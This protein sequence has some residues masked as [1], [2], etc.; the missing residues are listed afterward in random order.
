MSEPFCFRCLTFLSPEEFLPSPTPP[1]PCYEKRGRTKYIGTQLWIGFFSGITR[2]FL[3]WCLPKNQIRNLLWGYFIISQQAISGRERKTIWKRWRN[4]DSC[5][6]QCRW[7]NAS[8]SSAPCM[9][10]ST[11]VRMRYAVAQEKIKMVHGEWKFTVE[12]SAVASVQGVK[13][14]P[15]KRWSVEAEGFCMQASLDSDNNHLQH[16]LNVLLNVPFFPGLSCVCVLV[17]VG[18][19]TTD[20]SIIQLWAGCWLGLAAR[21]GMTLQLGW[22]SSPERAGLS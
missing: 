3:P 14:P 10:K 2:H 6:C 22:K 18:K 16:A 11:S 1:D 12:G 15:C 4:T 8:Y 13:S 9:Q 7:T 21:L 20:M 5:P 17:Y 19:T